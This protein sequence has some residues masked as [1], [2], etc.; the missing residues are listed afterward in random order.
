MERIDYFRIIGFLAFVGSAFLSTIFHYPVFTVSWFVV[1]ILFMSLVAEELSEQTI[2]VF[3]ALAYIPLG[4][5]LALSNYVNKTP[6]PRDIS[7]FALLLI[8]FV[9]IELVMAII[10]YIYQD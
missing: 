10:W 6:A 3:T 1:M 5:I 8:V 4:L 2:L 9:F 7:E